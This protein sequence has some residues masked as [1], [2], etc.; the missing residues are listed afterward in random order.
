MLARVDGPDGRLVGVHRTYLRRDGCGQWQ[1]RDRATFGPIAG[2]A[3]RLASVAETLMVGAGIE[4]C[5]AAMQATKLPAWAALS[6]SGLVALILPPIVRTVI[7]LA[8]H[9]VSGADERAARNAA[10][11]WRARPAG[12]HLHVCASRRRRKRRLACRRRRGVP[13]CLA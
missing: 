8:D 11:R 13:C 3:V 9:D 1:R 2:G 7:I 12:V 10:A 4:T 5:L 6:T